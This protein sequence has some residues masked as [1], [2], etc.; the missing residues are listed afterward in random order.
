MMGKSQLVGAA[1][2]VSILVVAFLSVGFFSQIGGPATG[3]TEVMDMLDRS[4]EVPLTV[5]KVAGIGIGALRTLVYLECSEMIVGR[6]ANDQKMRDVLPYLLANP[7]LANLTEVESSGTV[8]LEAIISLA[9]DV[10][11]ASYYDTEDADRIQ[12]NT[13]IP[14]VV[15]KPGEGESEPLNYTD[16]NNDFYQSLRF[17]GSIVDK[18]ERAEDVIS[19]VKALANDLNER[20]SGIP[21]NNRPTVYTGGLSRKGS[22][23]LTMTQRAYPPFVLTNSKNAAG[24]IEAPSNTVEIDAEQLIDWDPDII[25]VDEVNLPLVL[26]DLVDPRFSNLSAINSGA[27]YG[28]LPY[29]RYGLNH[30]VVFAD[31]YY[32]GMVLYPDHF[33][34]TD[35]EGK[36]DEIFSFL[37]GEPVYN[38]MKDALG[39]FMKIE[40]DDVGEL[41]WTLARRPQMSTKGR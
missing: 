40:L 24:E 26:E 16:D 11:I 27:V 29:P 21:D 31:S 39:G 13:L 32:V 37:V 22:F 10:I 15:V 6:G 34:D 9:P 17:I 35:P 19:Y 1:V 4:V 7:E 41:L 8:N 5:S 30:G 18:E 33:N 25:F 23:G 28:L 14:V 12:E 38:A 20:T 2:V 36:A 3:T